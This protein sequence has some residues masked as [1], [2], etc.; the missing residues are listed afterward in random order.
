MQGCS[1]NWTI[2]SIVLREISTRVHGPTGRAC[3]SMM[4]ARSS[5]RGDCLQVK[6]AADRSEGGVILA[7]ESKDRP[8]VGKVCID[9]S[10]SLLPSQDAIGSCEAVQCVTHR[11]RH[12]QCVRAGCGSGQ[13]QG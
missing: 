13:W 9:S 6:E 2:S 5:C 1:R 3:T 8:T 7:A 4:L 10:L 11:I 12:G